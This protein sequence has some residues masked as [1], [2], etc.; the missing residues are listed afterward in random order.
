VSTITSTGSRYFICLLLRVSICYFSAPLWSLPFLSFFLLRLQVVQPC[1]DCPC[2]PAS[3]TAGRH[4]Q[5]RPVL[6]SF[7]SLRFDGLLIRSLVFLMC[8]SMCGDALYCFNH[9]LMLIHQLVLTLQAAAAAAG[10]GSVAKPML[11]H[12]QETTV[13]VSRQSSDQWFQ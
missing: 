13:C 12:C 10:D 6:S 1:S 5:R 2:V 8:F 9:S 3:R 7:F 11:H 4:E